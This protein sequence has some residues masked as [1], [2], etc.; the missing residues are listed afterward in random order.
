[1]LQTVGYTVEFF[2]Y[3]VI[4]STIVA[5]DLKYFTAYF[6]NLHEEMM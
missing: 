4:F 1:M 2:G 5:Y 3:G 6:P